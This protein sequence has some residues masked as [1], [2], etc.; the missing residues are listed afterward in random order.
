MQKAQ[1]EEGEL[2]AEESGEPPFAFALPGKSEQRQRS[3]YANEAPAHHAL[4]FRR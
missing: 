2:E 3:G 1:A 4:R